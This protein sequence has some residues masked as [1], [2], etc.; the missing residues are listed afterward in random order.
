MVVCKMSSLKT[1]VVF[2]LLV[3]LTQG[4]AKAP[5]LGKEV[6]PK[7]V[8]SLVIWPDGKGLPTGSGTVIEGQAIYEQQCLVCHG[9]KGQNGINDS[10]VGGQVP[11]TAL[12]TVRTVASYWPYATSLFDYVRRTMPYREPGSLTDEQ[13]Y[14]VVAYLLFLNEIVAEDTRLDA[15]QLKN[16]RLPNRKRFFSKYNLP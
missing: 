6:P 1:L 10:L 14:A 8:S 4:F 3:P 5:G 9:V 13:V 16:I 2:L 11:L 7:D 12:P 15:K